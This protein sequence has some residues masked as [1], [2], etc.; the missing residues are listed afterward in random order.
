G[1]VEEVLPPLQQAPRP[2]GVQVVDQAQ[3]EAPR[4]VPARV[5]AVR[6]FIQNVQAELK[7]VTW[8]TRPE[9]IKA[10]RMV[11]IL[12]IVLGVAIGLVDFLLQLIL[13]R[14][15]ALIAR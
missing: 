2:Q 8:P 3:A 7:K 9:L 12:S 13:V 14:G 6:G 11:V 1:G 10:T 4:G 5:E 15:V